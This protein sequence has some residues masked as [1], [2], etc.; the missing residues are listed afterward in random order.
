MVAAVIPNKAAYF[1]GQQ[2]QYSK[3]SLWGGVSA[4]DGSGSGGGGGGGGSG[5]DG[6]ASIHQSFDRDN[7]G[8][9]Y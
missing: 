8:I 4:T 1:L 2:F 9:A 5:G 7:D 3:I 6:G